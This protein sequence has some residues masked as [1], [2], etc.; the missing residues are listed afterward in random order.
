MIKKELSIKAIEQII[1]YQFHNKELLGKLFADKDAFNRQACDDGKNVF[2]KFLAK[3]CSKPIFDVKPSYATLTYEQKLAINKEIFE[4]DN[5]HNF[6]AS[7]KK[8][9][10][11]DYL[12]FNESTTPQ[13][14][15]DFVFMLINAIKVDCNND[16]NILQT[17]INKITLYDYAIYYPN[18]EY[19]KLNL[20]FVFDSY[21]CK[22][23]LMEIY[24]P[25]YLA[26]SHQDAT[27]TFNY[28][29]YY[30]IDL[31]NKMADD[32][33][34]LK[35]IWKNIKFDDN[36][37][38]QF[39]RIT[40]KN[41]LYYGFLWLHDEYYWYFLVFVAKFNLAFFAKSETK[42]EAK[43]LAVIA[44]IKYYMSNDDNEKYLIE[45]GNAISLNYLFFSLLITKLDLHHY[46][47][48][49]LSTFDWAHTSSNHL[50]KELDNNNIFSLTVI[51]KDQGKS[52]C[53]LFVNGSNQAFGFLGWN[54]QNALMNACS[55]LINYYKH[56]A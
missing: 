38:G 53:M 34:E 40:K 30:F 17:V 5:A 19:D 33:D 11:N 6:F 27:E 25:K 55:L 12:H 8:I 29:A 45:D 52:T 26:Y 10:L 23:A 48:S 1:C 56:L 16:E 2:E 14:I 28:L 3:A 43:K 21:Q 32:N 54:N 44:F 41:K 51:Q 49:R 18:F 42:K 46:D 13:A 36:L 39:D 31:D 22:H 50:I 15:Y 9:G 24:C 4:D 35:A 20:Q 7:L 47:K 37:L